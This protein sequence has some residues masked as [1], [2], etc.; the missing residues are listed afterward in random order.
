MHRKHIL[1]ISGIAQIMR[2]VTWRIGR[3]TVGPVN[4]VGM[5]ITFAI[6]GGVANKSA[7]AL[8]CRGVATRLKVLLV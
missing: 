2:L 8:M 5:M 3:I 6:H 1:H 4:V 7:Q